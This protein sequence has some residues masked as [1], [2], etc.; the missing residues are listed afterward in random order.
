MDTKKYIK[1]CLH[2]HY[3]WFFVKKFICI[4]YAQF[5]YK[6]LTT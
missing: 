5:L 1:K 4:S 2:A 3:E 6:L